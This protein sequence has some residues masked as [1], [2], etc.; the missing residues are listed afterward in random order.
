MRLRSRN[1]M[2][3]M[4]PAMVAVVLLWLLIVAAPAAAGRSTGVA[5]A[6]S[7]VGGVPL[8]GSAASAE[9]VIVNLNPST[10]SV[11]KDQI[12]TVDIQVVAGAQYVDGAEIH[13][14]F[15]K[16]Y[17]QVVDS[18][19]NPVGQIE[20]LSG[21]NA[22]LANAVY[23]D[24]EPARIL[25]AAGILGS[26]AKPSGTFPLARIRF[27][28]LWGT[29]GGSTPLVFGTELPYKTDIYYGVTSVL[30]GVENGSVTISG[31]T[32]PAT[33]TPTLT[34]TRT[35]TPTSTQTSTPTPTA[36][37]TQT[38]VQSP[39]PTPSATG[40]P[41][42]TP[43]TS[44][45]V[46]CA[47]LSISFQ[48]GMLPNPS[49]YGVSDTYLYYWQPDDHYATWPYLWINNGS[50]RPLLRFDLS[51]NIPQG[52]T[53]ISATLHMWQ[54]GDYQQNDFNALTVEV[55][56]VTRS[57][58]ASEASWNRA[59]NAQEWAAG[60][61]DSALDRS[62]ASADSRVLTP[63]TSSYVEYTW[64]ITQMVQDWVNDPVHN[65]G[66]IL[67]G[68]GDSQTFHLYSSEYSSPEQG[69][70]L[71][72]L[73]CP[74]VP[75]ATPTQTATPTRTATATPTL[76]PTP[77]YTATPVPGRIE[78]QVWNDLNGDGVAD[79]GEPGLA[80]AT[81]YLYSFA[82]PGSPVRP[83]VTTGADGN[84]QFT[85]L[86]PGW[87][88]L[89]RANPAGYLS[90]TGDALDLLLSSGAVVRVSFGAWIPVTVTATGTP[91]PT[92]TPTATPTPT[93]TV[94]L[95]PTRTL[96]AT[97]TVRYR[98]FLPIVQRI[99]VSSSG[100]GIASFSGGSPAENAG[101]S[102]S[103]Q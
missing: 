47:G 99:W 9:T 44:P 2:G 68:S 82:D 102:T 75:T 28:A 34:P 23:T 73:Y 66:L 14:Y 74:A 24:T 87:Y 21:W 33:P 100:A 46:P 50:A 56:Q 10:S 67:I 11:A 40:T 38:P 32:P 58:V 57:W 41:T 36:T 64:S 49:Y 54:R 78:G 65:A 89:M 90:T 43:T 103:P 31:E 81:L 45:T 95:T 8:G 3:I 94:T 60:G 48:N 86:T 91:P 17:L 27:K 6:I 37:T 77:T 101:R 63:P 61:A 70:K 53:V 62:L 1:W 22:P 16:T 39:T 92:V 30:G 71:R 15:S 35:A 85:D 42:P 55:F 79:G 4:L 72:V 29:G 18:A 80:G 69:P 76:T 19:G 88:S 25:F 5:P 52:S 13:L 26:G 98:I 97:P 84:F 93:H 12:F 51:Q 59:S 83:P 20:D 96:T 7:A